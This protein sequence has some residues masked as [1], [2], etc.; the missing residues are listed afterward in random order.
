MS[1]WHDTQKLRGRGTGRKRE[2]HTT[3][4]NAHMSDALENLSSSLNGG[5]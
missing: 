2:Q 5:K 1:S 4:P 3:I